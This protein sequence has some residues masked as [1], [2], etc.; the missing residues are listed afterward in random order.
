[1]DSKCLARGSQLEM[2]ELYWDL[3]LG[4]P[5][6]PGATMVLLEWESPFLLCCSTQVDLEGAILQGTEISVIEALKAGQARW[7]MPVK[8]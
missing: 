7:P 6:A 5:A 8:I 4:F 2:G 1:M 3:G